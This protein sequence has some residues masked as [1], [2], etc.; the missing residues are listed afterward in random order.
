MP[1]KVG[2]NTLLE[3]YLGENQSKQNENKLLGTMKQIV[4]YNRRSETIP[5]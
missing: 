1:V 2:D 4:L 3:D 5:D